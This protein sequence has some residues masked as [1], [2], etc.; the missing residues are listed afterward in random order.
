MGGFHVTS[1]V[2]SASYYTKCVFKTKNEYIFFK[3]F[4]TRSV[5][6]SASAS[7]STSTSTST[8]SFTSGKLAVFHKPA[9]AF[10]FPNRRAQLHV[11]HPC[12]SQ[13]NTF[14]YPPPPARS[15]T[16]PLLLL[17]RFRPAPSLVS[18]RRQ[19]RPL[20]HKCPSLPS[21]PPPC[22]HNRPP[23]VSFSI[24]HPHNS[25]VKYSPGAA[26]RQL[27]PC[28]SRHLA[29]G[30]VGVV[31]SP[32]SGDGN[33]SGQTFAFMLHSETLAEPP[34]VFTPASWTSSTVIHNS[35]ICLAGQPGEHVITVT[36]HEQTSFPGQSPDSSVISVDTGFYIR[37]LRRIL[38]DHLS[39][40]TIFKATLLPPAPFPSTCTPTTLLP[41]T[42]ALFWP[43]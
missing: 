10:S 7:T 21:S 13:Q 42:A 40:L 28:L 22:D 23:Q 6:C 12:P 2:F 3:S 37:S 29:P 14:P 31:L 34:Q 9:L 41:I 20:L 4:K 11:P 43:L 15:P 30:T 36:L 19:Y 33:C 39:F 32:L 5:L 16:P 27:L 18:H 38:S 24:L 8:F 35:V 25:A 17:L 1:D 26:R